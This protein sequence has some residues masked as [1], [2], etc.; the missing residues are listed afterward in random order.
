MEKVILVISDATLKIAVYGLRC[1]KMY[2]CM[3]HRAS[4]L[5]REYCYGDNFLRGMTLA[6]QVEGMG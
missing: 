4:E 3:L 1:I 5:E 6:G 2:Y